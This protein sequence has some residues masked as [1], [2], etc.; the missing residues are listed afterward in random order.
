LR[1]QALLTARDL[2][3]IGTLVDI[4]GGQGQ[5][6]AAALTATPGLRG[7]LFDRPEVLPGAEAFL[8]TA[9]EYRV[10]LEAAGFRQITIHATDTPYSV[11]EAVRL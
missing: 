1:A 7:V 9:E 5:L 6:R 2:S 8:A 4:G 3:G 11:V 10:L